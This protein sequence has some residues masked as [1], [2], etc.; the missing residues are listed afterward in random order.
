M[1]KQWEQNRLDIILMG[2]SLS[3][4]LM[5]KFWLKRIVLHWFIQCYL[6]DVMAGVCFSAICQLLMCFWMKRKIRSSE[7]ILLL[8]LAGAYWEFIAPLYLPQ[9]TTDICDLPAYLL[10]GLIMI[11][12]RKLQ[13]KREKRK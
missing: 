4:Y 8:Y 5:N 11:A 7:N 10:G 3:I 6:N 2:I 13:R 9:A 12:L 1:K